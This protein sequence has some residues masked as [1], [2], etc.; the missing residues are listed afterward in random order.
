MVKTAVYNRAVRTAAGMDYDAAVNAN[1]FQAQYIKIALSS[2]KYDDK[3]ENLTEIQDIKIIAPVSQ[4]TKND[5]ASIT[6]TASYTNLG[7]MEDFLLNTIGLYAYKP[8]IGE[9]LH[10]VQTAN[11]A[12]TIPAD[13]GTNLV[14]ETFDFVITEVDANCTVL[15]GNPA[16]LVTI[17]MLKDLDLSPNTFICQIPATEYYKKWVLYDAEGAM[18][19]L[20]DAWGFR[21]AKLV[22]LPTKAVVEITKG[23]VSIYSTKDYGGKSW[24]VAPLQGVDGVQ[25]LFSNDKI[26]YL[27][28]R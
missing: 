9:I 24:T 4:V 23:T 13:D 16:G 17:D 22:E 15:Q 3:L 18:T 8:D 21:N 20:L 12:D 27:I 1:L 5:A 28:R 10:S 2:Q 25:V 6:V 14:T 11:I 26:L 19:Q 7:L